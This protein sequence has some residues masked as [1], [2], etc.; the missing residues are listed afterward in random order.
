MKKSKILIASLLLVGSLASAKTLAT[1]NG[2]PITQNDVEN[3]LQIVTK[4]GYSQ[5]STKEKR[6]YK[7]GMLEELI[8]RELI[9][10][11]AKKS[12]ILNSKEFKSELERIKKELAIQVWHKKLVDSIKIST[13]E[14]KKYY[15]QNKVEFQTKASVHARHILLK[16][17]GEAKAVIAKLKGLKGE[18]LKEKFMELARE[19]STGPSASR[20]GDLGYF[21]KAQM[22]KPFSEK[23]F[24][25]K[26]GE[27]TKKPVKTQFGYHVIYVEDVRPEFVRSF[28]EVKPFIEERLKMEKFKAKVANEL[29]KLKA[30]AK[31]SK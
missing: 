30:K 5:L 22:V 2:T 27:Y 25:M 23:V 20:G 26:K 15:N 14:L 7:K 10:S 11:D 1:V 8:K 17:E 24:S 6:K 21:S 4:G 9:F 29:E 28:D 12:G 19:K 16:T 18:K 31:I 3:A 13:A